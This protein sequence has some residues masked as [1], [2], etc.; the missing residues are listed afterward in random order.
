M[1]SSI[2]SE[3][4]SGNCSLKWDKLFF[5]VAFP[6]CNI[7]S[8]FNVS[9]LTVMYLGMMLWIVGEYFSPYLGTFFSFFYFLLF[10]RLLSLLGGLLEHYSLKWKW[11]ASQSVMSDSL[12]PHGLY[13]PW[14]SPGQNTGVGSLSLLKEILP[15]QVSCIT[16]KFFT[17]WATREAH[18]G[19]SCFLHY[20]PSCSLNSN[21]SS[22]TLSHLVFT[23]EL[24][25]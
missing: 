14:N 19:F 17:S 22:L 16:G 3:R 8:L 12:R 13:S 18:W 24:L 7:Y 10:L 11:S 1:V 23:V 15:T 4:L 2:S 25:Q 5:L 21:S 20:F 6:V 9:S